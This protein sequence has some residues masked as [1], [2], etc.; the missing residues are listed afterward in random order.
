MKHT[1]ERPGVLSIAGKNVL[2]TGAAGGLGLA[3]TLH[4]LRAGARVVAID[5][6]RAKVEAL[7][8]SVKAEGLEGLT[9]CEADLSDLAG[10]R[11]RLDGAAGK[12]G[13]LDVVI[14]NAAIYPS[15]NFEDYTIEEFQAVQRVN[16]DA[17]IVCVQAALPGMREKGWGRIINIA[18]VTAYGGWAK[19]APYVQSKGAL[20]GLTRAWAREFGVY[21]VTVNAVAP[22]AFPTDAEKIHPDPEGYTRFV[23]DHQAVKRR[24]DPDDI[25]HALM[26]L[27]SEEAGFITGQVLNVDG[28]WVMH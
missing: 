19:L 25:A 7:R 1:P 17:G 18:S 14:N 21:G 26:F 3:T 27:A 23:L 24:G 12:I 16:V 8:E 11:R 22:G 6:D 2:Y 5:N 13:G 4:F 20:I 15:K 9:M 10:L 28:G